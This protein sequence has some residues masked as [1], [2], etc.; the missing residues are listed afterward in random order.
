M[1]ECGRLDR[2]F[3]ANLVD[4]AGGTYDRTLAARQA[5]LK[6]MLTALTDTGN[7]GRSRSMMLPLPLVSRWINLNVRVIRCFRCFSVKMM[8]KSHCDDRY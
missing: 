5:I 6:I 4:R 8:M 3:E 7:Q 2:C 1:P